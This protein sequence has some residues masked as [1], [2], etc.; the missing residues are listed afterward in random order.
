MTCEWCGIDFLPKPSMRYTPQRFCSRTCANRGRDGVRPTICTV[1]GCDKEPR[2]KGHCTGHY[3]RLRAWGELRPEIP[4]R[5]KRPRKKPGY[6]YDKSGY[7][8][9]RLPDHP[10]AQVNGFVLEHRLVMAEMLGRPLLP[11]ETVHHKNGIKDDN[12]PENLELWVGNHGK[13]Q[14]VEDK[15]RHAVQL[16]TLYAPELLAEGMLENDLRRAA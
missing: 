10:N 4:L 5:K 8:A 14:K 7:A 15:I 16:L 13:G 11:G 2:A 9:L 1:E 12:R 6:C 3:A